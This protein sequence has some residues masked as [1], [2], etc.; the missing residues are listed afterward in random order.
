VVNE[1]I[2]GQAFT[3]FIEDAL[4]ETT[5]STSAISAE[6]GRFQ[7]GVVQAITKSGGNEFSGS[8][9][10]NVENDDWTAITPFTNDTRTDKVLMTHEATLGGPI[11][12]DRLWFFSA[13]R[14]SNR[15]TSGTTSITSIPFP[16]IRDQK[17]YEGKLTW[18]ANPSHTFKGAY[19]KIQDAED[20][21]F[22]PPIMD[23]ASL[24]NRATPQN[25]FSANY[26][27][28]ISPKFF[29]ETQYSLRH[30]TFV[31]SGSSGSATSIFFPLS[32][33]S[34]ICIRLLRYS[35]LYFSGLNESASVATSCS[36]IWSS[37]GRTLSAV[38][39]LKVDVSTS[40]SA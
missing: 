7:G 9:R 10:L 1:N 31:G 16:I 36:A 38:G 39:K 33:A 6:Y 19:T 8:Y 17:R 40:S 14:F 37:A 25:I 3:L 24:V 5:V 22:F 28:I 2:R 26:T 35:L 32:L 18:A 13:G 34:M 30:F 29:V 23:R 20:G 12:R 27:G 21:N 4:Q 15:E 11:F